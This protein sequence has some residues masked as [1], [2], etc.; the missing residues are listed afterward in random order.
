MRRVPVSEAFAIK[1]KGL[2][3][4][5]HNGEATFL[6]PERDGRVKVAIV[7]GHFEFMDERSA[8]HRA[9]LQAIDA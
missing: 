9:V 3:I 1:A 4:R 2:G 6:M 8:Q 5:I 7:D